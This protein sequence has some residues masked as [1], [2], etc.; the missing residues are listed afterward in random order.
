PWW[1][2]GG[3][4]RS[5]AGHVVAGLAT[6]GGGSASG[7]MQR[8]AS[9]GGTGVGVSD[10]AVAAVAGV[11]AG[12]AGSALV[13]AG[14][15][16]VGAVVGSSTRW[17]V[18]PASRQ[19]RSTGGRMGPGFYHPPGEGVSVRYNF[20]AC[21]RGAFDDSLFAAGRVLLPCSGWRS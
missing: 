10:V 14:S 18:A 6:G 12:V 17:H 20:W 5:S 11:V 8:P 9:T 15:T 16:G 13:L 4:A 3:V 2:V 19:K 7:S 21:G 1:R